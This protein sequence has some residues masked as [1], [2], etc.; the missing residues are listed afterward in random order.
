MISKNQRVNKTLFKD[1]AKKPKKSLFGDFCTISYT[2]DKSLI[3]SRFSVV[4][5]KK[6]AKTAV[7]R[8]LIKRRFY[9]VIESLPVP[10]NPYIA[11]VYVK[12]EAVKASFTQISAEVNSI[13]SKIA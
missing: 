9:A 13:L 12:K 5:S 2:L 3:K 11:I 8:N 1:L 4:V 6:V 7:S 10:Q